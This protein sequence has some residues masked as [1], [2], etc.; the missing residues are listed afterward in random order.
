[1]SQRGQC[2]IAMATSPDTASFSSD[3]YQP[4][5]DESTMS[6]PPTRQLD[7]YQAMI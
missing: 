5:K 2:V 7:F 4:Q 1:M 6:D 3:G